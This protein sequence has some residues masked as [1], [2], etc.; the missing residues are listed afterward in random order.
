MIDPII[1]W[2]LKAIPGAYLAEVI[3]LAV[4]I[5]SIVQVFKISLRYTWRKP[6]EPF[7]HFLSLAAAALAG[8]FIPPGDLDERMGI[9]AVAWLVTF[10]VAKYGLAI[11]KWKWPDLWSAINMERRRRDKR[12]PGGDDRR[13]NP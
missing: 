3:K 6:S 2:F 11:L 1:D 7:I 5:F 4:V 9:A 13:G 8:F 10:V 12:P